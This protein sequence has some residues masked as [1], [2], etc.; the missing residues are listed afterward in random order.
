MSNLPAGAGYLTN[1]EKVMLSK[2]ESIEQSIGKLAQNQNAL[3]KSI[4]RNGE[5]N[6]LKNSQIAQKSLFCQ[7]QN[8]I[9]TPPLIKD[10]GFR[11]FSQFDEDG[12]I[13]Y[14]FAV[15]GFTNKYCLDIAF[16]NP[17]GANTTNLLLNWAFGGLLICGKEKEKLV[18]QDFFKSDYNTWHVPPKIINN[19]VTAENIKDILSQ[20][21]VPKEIDFFSLDIDGVDYYILQE[22]LK[23]IQPRVVVVEAH[24]VWGAE[25]SVTVRYSADFNRFNIHKDYCGASIPAFIKIMKANKYK[26]VACNKYGFNIFFIKENIDRGHLPEIKAEDCFAN[27]PNYYIEELDKRRKEVEHLDWIEV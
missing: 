3:Q 22:V 19:W 20:N 17:I 4:R 2:L 16:F 24:N 8:C 7:I 13:M 9:N 12:I 23:V 21:K 1:K 6:M 15:I 11:V 25:K 18:S 5:V 26:L 14:L 10:F 27:L